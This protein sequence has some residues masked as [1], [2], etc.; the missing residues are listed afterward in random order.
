M[1]ILRLLYSFSLCQ[2]FIILFENSV[3]ALLNSKHQANDF[4]VL[5]ERPV[6]GHLEVGWVFAGLGDPSF[7]HRA[8]TVGQ[9][10][11]DCGPV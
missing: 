4:R 9:T 7:C 2:Q 3:I 5:L 11:A 10:V 6:F 1:F 8:R